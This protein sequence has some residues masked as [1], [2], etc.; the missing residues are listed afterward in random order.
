M[1]AARFI[2]IF[3]KYHAIRYGYKSYGE[4]TK[5]MTLTNIGRI[6][7][8]KSMQKYVEHME[9]VMYPTRKS[10]I[11]GGMVAINDELVISFARTIKEADLIRA[12]FQELT[13]THNLNVH[14]YSND[15]R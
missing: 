2:P 9:M 6:E 12:F 13:Q 7:L 1:L 14:V 10:P 5:S 11:N 15:G 4:R 8:P 3:L